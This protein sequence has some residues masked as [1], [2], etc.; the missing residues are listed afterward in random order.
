MIIEK[1]KKYSYYYDNNEKFYKLKKEID[2]I[3]Y[4]I[5][6][7]NISI[8]FNYDKSGII[9]HNMENFY[10][11]RIYDIKPNT[12]EDIIYLGAE[13]LNNKIFIIPKKFINHGNYVDFF[14][15]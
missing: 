2:L 7:S 12:N 6:H 3:L 10:T 1:F 8:S 15:G 4:K 11:L 14:F 5:Y 13:I 9:Q